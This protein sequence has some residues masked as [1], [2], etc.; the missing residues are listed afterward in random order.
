MLAL[1]YLLCLHSWI[2]VL[3]E[4]VAL[5]QSFLFV[6]IAWQSYWSPSLIGICVGL[7][8]ILR[9]MILEI[10]VFALDSSYSVSVGWTQKICQIIKHPLKTPPFRTFLWHTI[11]FGLSVIKPKLITVTSVPIIR[12]VCIVLGT[13]NLHFQKQSP[14]V[15]IA[16]FSII[17]N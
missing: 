8:F 13:S 14:L 11:I 7:S 2:T 5:L 12:K 3:D 6:A 9:Q 1:F 10:Y 17:S 16:I 15:S 4:G